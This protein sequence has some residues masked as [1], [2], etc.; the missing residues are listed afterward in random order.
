MCFS[1]IILFFFCLD[2]IT[3]FFPVKQNYTVILSL[4]IATR[5]GSAEFVAVNI[6]LMYFVLCAFIC[7]NYYDFPADFFFFFVTRTILECIIVMLM[8]H[9]DHLHNY[10]TVCKGTGN[11][12]VYYYIKIMEWVSFWL[13]RLRAY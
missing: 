11:W 6:R 10:Y 5:S 4:I 3:H 1:I 7:H 13:V 9:A 8:Q 2:H 12:G